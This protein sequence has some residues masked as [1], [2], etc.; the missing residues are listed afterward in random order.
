MRSC[1]EDTTGPSLG[2]ARCLLAAPCR[3]G[4][5]EDPPRLPVQF[6]LSSVKFNL[7]PLI[8]FIVVLPSPLRTPKCYY[9]KHNGK[10]YFSVANFLAE[11]SRKRNPWQD[12]SHYNPG[13]LIANQHAGD[14]RAKSGGQKGTAHAHRALNTQHPPATR[15]CAIQG[16][17]HADTRAHRTHACQGVCTVTPCHTYAPQ[18]D[19]CMAIHIH[20]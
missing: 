13:K 3:P 18:P 19:R 20:L 10:G 5:A 8:K 14:C 16:I 9:S 1:C 12:P 15:V 2:D 7:F 11:E 17:A 4:Q 6:Q